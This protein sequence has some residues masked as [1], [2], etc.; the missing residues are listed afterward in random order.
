MMPMI[1]D[2]TR[3]SFNAIRTLCSAHGEAGSGNRTQLLERLENHSCG[4][5]CVT[6]AEDTFAAGL[7]LV[8]SNSRPMTAPDRIPLQ[9]IYDH[10]GARQRQRTNR[11]ERIA[12]ADEEDKD[13]WKAN[14]PIVESDDH[15][16][17]VSFSS[18]EMIDA[19]F[20]ESW[21]RLFG[22]FRRR[23]ARTQ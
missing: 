13:W 19:L 9:P 4:P 7:Y 20:I 3:T 6:L 8:A 2:R 5:G 18:P 10:S 17:E 23:Q 12:D 1:R 15:N 22:S 16:L 11:K 14:W 21:L